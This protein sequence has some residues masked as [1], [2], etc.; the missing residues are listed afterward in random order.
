MPNHIKWS[1][2]E[3]FHNI[4]KATKKYPHICG[5]DV[6]VTYRAKVKLDGTN[7][8]VQINKDGVF[9]QSRKRLITS[10]Q[11]NV[12]FAKWVESAEDVRR[13]W[14]EIFERSHAHVTKEF[15][16]MIVFGEWCGR[17][18]QRRC[19]ISKIDKKIFAVFAIQFKNGEEDVAFYIEPSVLSMFV[20]GI[21]DV[22][23]LPWY[24]DQVVVDWS[25]PHDQFGDIID[26]MNAMVTEIEKC[27][28]WVKD[29]F[30]VEGL[31]EGLV[32]YPSSHRTRAYFGDLAFKAKGEEHKVVKTKTPVQV[33]PETANSI[34]EFVNLVT[35]EARLEQ[36]ATEVAG[37]ELDFDIKNTGRFIGS[38]CRDVQKECVDE[39]EASKLEWKPVSKAVSQKAREWYVH[40]VHNT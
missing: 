27:D 40:K 16:T 12:E 38:V 29:T 18:I 2:I 32:F 21:P 25:L 28:P 6:H 5:E 7:G 4:R 8:G 36:M 30:G 9:P 20:E 24:G 23:V 15:D 33:D 39:L 35:T 19:S 22:F 14:S 10:E 34:T 3:A 26:K 17:G 1:S 37:G 31:G 13:S 11:D